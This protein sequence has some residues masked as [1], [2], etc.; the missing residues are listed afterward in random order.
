ML[1]HQRVTIKFKAPKQTQLLVWSVPQP[2]QGVRMVMHGLTTKKIS[3]ARNA[4]AL[5]PI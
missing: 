3:T 5:S 1:V 4:L 2:S